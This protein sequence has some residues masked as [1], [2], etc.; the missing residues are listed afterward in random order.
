MLRSSFSSASF[1]KLPY[2]ICKAIESSVMNVNNDSFLV[3]FNRGLKPFN[4]VIVCMS[5][6]L[7]TFTRISHF[8][9]A[10]FQPAP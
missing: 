10:K 2:S 1:S 7:Q 6:N 9:L 4:V 8:F 3:G 5:T